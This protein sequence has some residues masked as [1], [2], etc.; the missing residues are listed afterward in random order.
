MQYIRESQD[1]FF[2]DIIY[3]LC[4]QTNGLGSRRIKLILV[5]WKIIIVG[6]VAFKG[7]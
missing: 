6:K 2:C 7:G 5:I 4:L 3:I 1:I